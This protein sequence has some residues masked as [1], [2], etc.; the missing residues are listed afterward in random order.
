M[1]EQRPIRAA[2]NAMVWKLVQMGGVKIIY[3]IRLLVLAILLGPAEFGLA[4]I[5][6][7]ATGFLLGMTNFGLIP[8]VV[9]AKDMDEEK[10]AAAWTFDLSRSL[11][12]AIL[13]I[14]FAPVIAKHCLEDGQKAEMLQHRLP[15]WQPHWVGMQAAQ[16]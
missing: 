8:A 5:A 14:I 2:G 12:V 13:T 7:S 3:L 15:R 4:A 11:I 9:Q 6:T 10:Y 1:I 16:Q